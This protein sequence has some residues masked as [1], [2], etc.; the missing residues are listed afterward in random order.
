MDGRITPPLNHPG[1][2]RT[3]WADVLDQ[4]LQEQQDPTQIRHCA[5]RTEMGRMTTSCPGRVSIPSVKPSV[6]SPEYKAVLRP[7]LRQGPVS[8]YDVVG[9]FGATP[10]DSRSNGARVRNEHVVALTASS[11]VPAH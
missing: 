6:T 4:A 1:P 2:A 10:H 9:A 5:I 3:G 7:P 11:P 8:A